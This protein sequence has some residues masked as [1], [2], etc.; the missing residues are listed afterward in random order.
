MAHT[1]ALVGALHPAARGLALRLEDDPAVERVLGLSA[2][3]PPLLGPKFEFVRAAPGTDSF[4]AALA[5]ADTVALF[6]LV[7]EGERDPSLA[8]ELVDLTLRAATGASTV[9]LWSSGLVYGAHP[10][11]PVP[12]QESQPLRPNDDFALAGVLADIER[13]VLDGAG[14]DGGRTVTVLRVGAVWAPSWGTF[15][16]RALQAPAMVGVRGYDPPL[17]ALDPEDATDALALA[18]GGGLPG[19]YNV[20]PADWVPVRDAARSAGKRRLQLP[21]PLAFNTAERL[22]GLG[23]SPASPGEL[24]YHMHPWV[25]DSSRLRAAGWAPRSGT[26]EAFAAAAR[27]PVDSVAVGGVRVRRS[28]LYKGAAAGVAMV[29]ALALV[30]RQARRPGRPA[31]RQAPSG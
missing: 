13:A 16:G 29:A 11:N 24:R 17:Q 4:A 10:H 3:E 18:V 31:R 22:H 9:V 14:Q 28:D 2:E 30:R 5:D 8:R 15:L 26:A 6:P 20:A 12:I 1:V 23:I 19:T 21:E 25:L 7:D 27:M